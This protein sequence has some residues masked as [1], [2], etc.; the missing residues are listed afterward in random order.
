VPLI[1]SVGLTTSW[2][3]LKILCRYKTSIVITEE[4]CIMISINELFAI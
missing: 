3:G 4:Y 2:K 1:N